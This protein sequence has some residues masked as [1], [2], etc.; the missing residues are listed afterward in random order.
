MHPASPVSHMRSSVALLCP[1]ARSALEALRQRVRIVVPDDPETPGAGA[2]EVIAA[3]VRSGTRI[4][5]RF[6]DAYPRLRAIVR[7]GNG[8]DNIDRS[9]L[10]ARNI[11]LHRN[12]HAS[13]QA[14]AEVALGGLLVLARR[15]L[16]AH[17]LVAQKTW[18]KTDLVG[19][20]LESLGVVVWG[21]GPVGRATRRMLLPHCADVRFAAWPSVDPALPTRDPQRALREADVH[22]LALPLRPA[23][24]GLVGRG[25]LERATVR[26]PYLVNVGRHALL[27]MSAVV[28]AL[29]RGDLRGLFIDPIDCGDL[30]SLAPLVTR[31]TPLNLLA[32]QHLGAQRGDVHERLGEW[33]VRKVDEL[34]KAEERAR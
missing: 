22:V 13:A 10:R 24:L 1:V 27:D 21:A 14:V 30:D 18:A 17:S 9:E 20:S 8:V 23:T 11:A 6:L 26:R 25:W 4:D 31:S 28:P 15:L 7:L 16:L 3:V 19:D 32:S 29:E 2:E 5:G 33:V 12:P 34:L